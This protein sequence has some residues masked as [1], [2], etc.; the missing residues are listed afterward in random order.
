[1]W[2]A[3]ERSIYGRPSARGQRAHSSLKFLRHLSANALTS[4]ICRMSRMKRCSLRWADKVYNARLVTQVA[5]SSAIRK[6]HVPTC[7]DCQ[8]SHPGIGTFVFQ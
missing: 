5:F 2:K 6:L 3:V 4:G 7:D 1:M 8:K